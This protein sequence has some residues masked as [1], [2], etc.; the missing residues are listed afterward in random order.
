MR[1]YFLSPLPP[2]PYRELLKCLYIKT[3]GFG[4]SVHFHADLS[5][6]YTVVREPVMHAHATV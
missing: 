3:D 6:K 1:A 2:P 5:R 4:K